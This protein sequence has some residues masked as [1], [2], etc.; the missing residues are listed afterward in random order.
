MKIST[1]IRQFRVICC[2]CVLCAVVLSVAGCNMGAPGL[3]SKEVHR[4][5]LDVVNT[6][7]VQ[8]QD[9]IDAWLLLDRPSRL[10]GK[11]VR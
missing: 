7:K 9:D 10:G 1:I 11:L 8:W 3:T 2:L 4:R 5:H 6:S